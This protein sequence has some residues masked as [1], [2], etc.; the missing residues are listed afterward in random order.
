MS[1]NDQ[2]RRQLMLLTWSTWQFDVLLLFREA[3]SRQW[4]G[5]VKQWQLYAT[6]VPTVIDCASPFMPKSSLLKGS[7]FLTAHSHSLVQTHACAHNNDLFLNRREAAERSCFS[8]MFTR[9][10][11]TFYIGRCEPSAPLLQQRGWCT[12]ATRYSRGIGE[13]ISFLRE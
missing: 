5:D 9:L 13:P 6:S 10:T 12:K 8:V 4:T 1:Q 2:C 11:H 7:P 3:V